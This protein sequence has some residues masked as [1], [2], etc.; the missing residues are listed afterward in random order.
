MADF[1]SV[2]EKFVKKRSTFKRKITAAINGLKDDETLDLETLKYHR[3]TIDSYLNDIEKLN[4]Q[5]DD[6]CIENGM[7]EDGEQEFRFRARV[8]RDLSA[9]TINASGRGSQPIT[10]SQTQN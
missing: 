7:G 6:L 8:F 3:G 1:R 2:T 5:I 4:S 9:L 10:P